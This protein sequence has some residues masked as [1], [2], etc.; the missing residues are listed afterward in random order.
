M[1]IVTKDNFYD[2]MVTNFH[3]VKSRNATVILFTN[4]KENEL[5]VSG[6][7]F[8]IRLPDEGLM[9]SFYSVFVGQLIAY[10]IALAKGYNPDKPRQLSKEITTK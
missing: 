8:V 2:D 6:V 3:Q 1:I 10:Y 4:A 7:D 9:S 5:D